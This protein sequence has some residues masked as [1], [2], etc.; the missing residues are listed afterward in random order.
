MTLEECLQQLPWR[1]IAAIAQA[2]AQPYTHRHDKPTFC[3]RLAAAIIEP[4]RLQATWRALSTEAQA[5]LRALVEAGGQM[6]REVFTA[7]FGSI[8]PYKPWR[9][10]APVAPWEN[11]V[12]PAEELAYRGLVFAINQGTKRRPLWA[13]VL[14]DE[15]KTALTPPPP[16]A[17]APPPLSH[18]WE[19]G[20]GRGRGEGDISTAV[21]TFL[22]FL[23]GE[24]IRPLHG[25]WLPPSTCRT[26]APRLSQGATHLP[27]RVRSERQL[28]YLSFVHYLA[29]RA[30][31]VDLEGKW[32][33]PTLVAQDWLAQPRAG[34][35]RALWEAWREDNE[36]NAELWARFR[37]P[38]DSDLT[39]LARFNRLLPVLASLAPGAY[40]LDHLLDALAQRDPALLQPCAPYRTWAEM[41]EET[42]AD[43][44]QRAR[45]WVAQMLTGPL[46]WFG[47]TSILKSQLSSLRSGSL[48]WGRR[49]W[50]VTTAPGRRTL[51]RLSCKF[52]CPPSMMRDSLS[53][54]PSPCRPASRPSAALPSR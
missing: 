5:A 45:Q 36:T 42:Q 32:L 19:R 24:D 50:D 22:C 15:I 43:F 3:A 14:P 38:G 31:L 39:P 49:C 8:R 53:R 29:D 35:L 34:R 21:L 26:L 30:G 48:R 25:R 7:R 40:P 2:Q 18:T 10:D 47:V 13:V 28:P 17:A 6:R 54:C 44:R 27:G 9:D 23:N 52:T 11:P 37:L 51:P 33:K 12:S 16:P 4:E 20:G 1:T 46:A 41:D